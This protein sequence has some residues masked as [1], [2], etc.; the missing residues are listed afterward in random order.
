MKKKTIL[1]KEINPKG[2]KHHLLELNKASSV[3]PEIK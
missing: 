3:G 1:E 2:I